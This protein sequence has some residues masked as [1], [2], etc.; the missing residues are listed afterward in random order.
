MANKTQKN[1]IH[2]RDQYN[3]YY[4]DFRGVDFS[5]DHTQ[6]LPNRLAYSL[7]MY[8]DYKSAQ[9]NAIETI[10]GFRRMFYAGEGGE[11]HG[12]HALNDD[13]VLVHVGTKLYRWDNYP[14][15]CGVEMKAVA[16]IYLKDVNPNGIG[17]Y[18]FFNAAE[19]AKNNQGKLG[20]IPVY[21]SA[22]DK[23]HVEHSNI[24][25]SSVEG[26]N[27]A[28]FLSTAELAVGDP[29]TVTYKEDTISADATLYKDMNDAK[30]VSFVVG[31]AL[32]ILDGKNYLRYAKK[33]NS[34]ELEL[35]D[36]RDFA[37][38]PTRY[39]GIVPAGDNANGGTEKEQRNLLSPYF[40]ATYYA[41]GENATFPLKAEVR[42]TENIASDFVIYVY[43][44]R[45]YTGF[46]Y[47]RDKNAIVF[48][49]SDIPPKPSAAGFP[50]ETFG[51]VITARYADVSTED[52]VVAKELLGCT[53]CAIFDNRV[54]F[55]GNPDFPNRVW[56]S[57]LND[58]QFFGTDNWVDDG[59]GNA[60]VTGMI[61]VANALAV[62]KENAM[63]EGA[64]YYHSP[65]VVE[66][67]DVYPKLYTSEQGLA[68][69]GCLGACANF[70][71]DPVFVSSRGLEAIGQLSVRY[72]R[73]LEHRSSLVDAYL[74]RE[75]LKNAFLCEWNRYL[76][77][78]V[79]GKMYMADSRQKY[80]DGISA[81][82][83]WYYCEGIGVYEGQYPEYRYAT[84]IS[85]EL[86]GATVRYC[87]ACHKSAVECA[88]G[89][90]ANIVEI[91]LTLAESVYNAAL[92]ETRNLMGEIVNAPDEDGKS[93]TEVFND[94]VSFQSDGITYSAIVYF[95][96]HEVYDGVTG[97]FIK[98]EAFLC[99]AKGNKTGGVFKRATVAKTTES[100]IFFGTEN[101]VVCCFNFD[102]RNEHGEI[103]PKYYTFDGRTI[104]C[105]CAT[106]MDNC[107]VPHL[108][109]ST[110]KKSTVVKIKTLP[111]SS[112]K[113]KVRT[114][115]VPY[116]QIDKISSAFF[117]FEDVAFDEFTFVTTA[118]SLF[119]LREKEK[120]WVEKQLYL[121]SDEYCKPFALFYISFRY[122]IAGRF[123]Q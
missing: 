122:F 28:F 41:D 31:N 27:L 63:H 102:K 52:A 56:H 88:C 82:Y 75:D 36:A 57:N 7:N 42:Y 71:D 5:S 116:K 81:Q 20:K 19:M 84:Q 98:Y 112:L 18:Y 26:S 47:D 115:R 12:I 43:G 118:E 89:N 109:K 30:S 78:F 54:F 108:T 117:T 10:P 103:P 97:D 45:Q 16:T 101:G 3:G 64:V 94:L 74:T 44:E 80:S 90:D 123:K 65:S 25:H 13:T 14:Y 85:T 35:R 96:I 29:L 87:A 99:D 37:P 11:V 9:G 83:E 77:L 6:V 53:L 95:T 93:T 58:P 33:S 4:G 73:A 17:Y 15:S 46:T 114:N 8:K 79:D 67:D 86:Q 2:K 70:L 113:V 120:K 107:G 59:V 91:P 24:K 100:N 1:L 111:R 40:K 104:V 34:E 106:K 22:V 32:Y 38:I 39:V 51:V 66:G 48:N 76:L 60:R 50:E 105:G 72:E 69:I 49:E 62:L 92:G 55:S 119:S 23:D 110:V 21:L 68:G 121:Y 61:P